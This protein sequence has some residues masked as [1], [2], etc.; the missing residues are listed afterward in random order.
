M[1]MA[2]YHRGSR[3]DIG[4]NPRVDLP[5]SIPGRDQDWEALAV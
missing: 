1:G 5:A 2:L 4:R 3:R